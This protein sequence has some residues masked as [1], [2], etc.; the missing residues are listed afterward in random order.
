MSSCSRGLADKEVLSV[1]FH[2]P[3]PTLGHS[4]RQKQE[5][6]PGSRG[7]QM[8]CEPGHQPP[9]RTQTEQEEGEGPP[10]AESGAPS[11][12][13]DTG[14]WRWWPCRLGALMEK[15]SPVRTSVN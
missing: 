1:T 12:D 5:A 15:D 4:Q 9:R 6:E 2:P 8:G 13:P 3:D 7:E 11:P 10:G 14:P